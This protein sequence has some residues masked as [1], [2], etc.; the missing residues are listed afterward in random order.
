MS[1]PNTPVTPEQTQA[2]PAAKP[3][4]SIIRTLTNGGSRRLQL[5]AIKNKNDWS[6]FV[7]EQEVTGSGKTMKLKT[8][9]RGATERVADEASAAA[10]ITK[11][12]AA[13]VKI[14]WQIPEGPKGFE[15]KPDAFDLAHLPKPGKK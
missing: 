14:G 9:D 1:T 5:N 2:T 6:C 4:T 11:V 13:A 7:V 15:A 8:I 10:Y 3:R 12:Q